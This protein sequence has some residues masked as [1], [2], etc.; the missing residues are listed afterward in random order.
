MSGGQARAWGVS[1]QSRPTNG[2]LAGEKRNACWR[3]G[4]E[5]GPVCVCVLFVDV[6][7]D[8]C[9]CVCVWTIFPHSTTISGDPG[10]KYI[11]HFIHYTPYSA[12]ICV[13]TPACMHTDKHIHTVI[14]SIAVHAWETHTFTRSFTH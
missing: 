4:G 7:G 12:V 13:L 14:L 9:V 1:R 5:T 3:R 10:E 11:Q 8:D 2:S 6:G